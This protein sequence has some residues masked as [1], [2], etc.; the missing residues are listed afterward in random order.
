MGWR[1]AQE[2]IRRKLASALDLPGEVILNLP[3]I[4][5]IGNFQVLIENHR[6]ILAY[7]SET[8]RVLV[9]TGEVAVR[10]QDLVL[11][12]ILPEE[13]LIEGRIQGI[14]FT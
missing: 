9:E 6:G 8:V 1:E 2:R 10:G 5:L 3:K 4:V 13:L 14:D 12:R 11:R 7:N